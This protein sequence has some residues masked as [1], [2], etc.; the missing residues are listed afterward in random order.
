MIAR[1]LLGTHVLGRPHHL[2]HARQS[3]TGDGRGD[4]ARDAE[5]HHERSAGGALDHD[6]VGLDVTVHDATSVCVCEGVR[7][8]LQHAHGVTRAERPGALHPI[9][10]A[11]SLDISHGEGEQIVALLDGMHRN[12]VRVRERRRH[13]RLAQEPFAQRL[14]G[15]EGGREHLECNEPVESEFARKIDGAHAA[16]AELALDAVAV[17][18]LR[19]EGVEIGERHWG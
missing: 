10:K 9:G 13:S 11:L 5:V 16:A 6:V 12:D 15:R 7:D 2:A 1:G 4:R 3:R 17:A 18:E 8:I 14:V 19:A